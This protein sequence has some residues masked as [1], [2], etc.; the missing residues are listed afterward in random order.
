MVDPVP[1]SDTD[2]SQFTMSG[3]RASVSA[4]NALQARIWCT[5]TDVFLKVG[6]TSDALL[7]V[8]EAQFL[9]PHFP[10]VMLS[11]GRVM[12]ASDDEKAS[13]E[14]Y[15]SALASVN[16]CTTPRGTTR[17]RSTGKRP[18]LCTSSTMK[19]GIGWGRCSQVRDTRNLQ[20]TAIGRLWS[21]S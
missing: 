8:R 21:W 18:L 14:L 3:P 16:S 10:S 5:V 15:C 17:P 2:F 13:G 20:P 7:C 9:A 6:K 1:A 19:R 4:S 12:Q 11:Y